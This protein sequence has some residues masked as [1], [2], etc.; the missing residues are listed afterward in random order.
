MP[1]GLSHGAAE[2]AKCARQ[3]RCR[4]Q[5]T[6]AEAVALA[7]REAGPALA[8][9]HSLLRRPG[10]DKGRKQQSAALPRRVSPPGMQ[11]AEGGG[12]QL[13]AAAADQCAEAMP[14]AAAGSGALQ[15][16][17]VAAVSDVREP[18]SNDEPP[19]AAAESRPVFRQLTR[20]TFAAAEPGQA[21]LLAQSVAVT[22]SYDIVA[23]QPLSERVMQQA[24]GCFCMETTAIKELDERLLDCGGKVCKSWPAFLHQAPDLAACKLVLC[25]R[26]D[27]YCW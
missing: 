17:N 12:V 21:G 14:E 6:P 13:T 5:Q 7:A 16:A 9:T 24:R 22:A 27:E 10:G 15:Q 19:A 2:L 23:V 20:L 25:F 11:T 18:N 8:F 4:V 1:L 26:V 3:N